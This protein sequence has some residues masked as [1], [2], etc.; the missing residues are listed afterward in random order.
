[1][2]DYNYLTEEQF[3]TMV[4]DTWPTK[5]STSIL[6]KHD[7]P[8]LKIN[9][10]G[11]KNIPVTKMFLYTDN[12][13]YQIT[14]KE[15]RTKE[16]EKG[17]LGCGANSR[18]SRA[19]ED[20][21]RGCDLADG[22]LTKETWLRILRDIVGYELVKIHTKKNFISIFNDEGS[23]EISSDGTLDI[24]T[25]GDVNLGP[26]SIKQPLTEG[27]TRSYVKKRYDSTPRPS[28][29]PPPPPPPMRYIEEKQ[30]FRIRRTP[31]DKK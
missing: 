11:T 1:M 16:T 28:T 2:T 8:K 25:T 13:Q 9:H 4:Q 31:T 6:I 18:K 10:D 19:G 14:I 24:K 17:Y 23:V 30:P 21:T 7:E 12:N 22:P 5:W 20:W 29:P 26:H 15:G 3:F 27:S